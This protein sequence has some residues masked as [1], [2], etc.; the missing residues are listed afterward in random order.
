MIML[1]YKQYSNKQL[2]KKDFNNDLFIGDFTKT[3]KIKKTSI[4]ITF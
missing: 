3:E 4:F 2:N 1:F